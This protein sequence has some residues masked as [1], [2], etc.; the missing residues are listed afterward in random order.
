MFLKKS[1]ILLNV[2]FNLFCNSASSIPSNM[3]IVSPKSLLSLTELTIVNSNNCKYFQTA[4]LVFSDTLSQLYSV[5]KSTFGKKN[6]F[7]LLSALKI[8]SFWYKISKNL[9]GYTL[10]Q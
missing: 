1:P 10:I 9:S 7:V 5:L 3:F 8:S 4:F 2:S 6:V